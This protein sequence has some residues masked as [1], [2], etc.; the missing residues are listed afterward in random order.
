MLL[1]G[2]YR[3][4]MTSESLN[5]HKWFGPW[6]MHKLKKWASISHCFRTSITSCFF[7]PSFLNVSLS[8]LF[9]RQRVQMNGKHGE[10]MSHS[11][12]DATPTGTWSAAFH[13]SV[14][15]NV[16]RGICR[17]NKTKMKLPGV[18]LHDERLLKVLA[19]LQHHFGS[20]PLHGMVTD[21][22]GVWTLK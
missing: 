7:V 2:Y 9:Q 21:K 17:E 13:C 15:F 16:D 12:S 5:Q 11:V 22:W 19:R 20:A 1:I 18:P 8:W 10:D 14:A 6:G 4:L 3:T